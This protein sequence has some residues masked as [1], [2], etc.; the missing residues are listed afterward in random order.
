MKTSEE[1]LQI[2]DERR[3]MKGKGEKQRYT[4]LKAEFQRIP[5]RDNQAFLNEQRKEV[6]EN[7]GMRKT[8]DFFQ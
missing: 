2:T 1:A 6:E 7:N 8:R 3:E 5:R 4:Q